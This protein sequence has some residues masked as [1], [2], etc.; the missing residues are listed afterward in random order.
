MP[1]TGH[2]S[3][4]STKPTAKEAEPYQIIKAL[5]YENGDAKEKK[6]IAKT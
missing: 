2:P 5:A 1:S 3:I 4:I 6:A